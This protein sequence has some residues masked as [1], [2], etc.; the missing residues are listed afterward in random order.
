MKTIMLLVH[1]DAGQ[2]ARFQVALDVARALGAHL[3]CLD[4]SLM[5]VLA[6]DDARIGQA[7][8]LADE[9]EREAKSR[10]GL[11]ARLAKE[12]VPWDWTDATGLMELESGAGS[13]LADLI[14]VNR[15]L[16]S[17]PVPDMR[18]VAS[19]LCLNWP[20]P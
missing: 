13:A 19:D 20:R 2:E 10:V 18:G 4:V 3:K 16:D 17:F 9:R 6:G 5:P 7:M 14:V 1:D 12:I 11:E 15:Q 8:L